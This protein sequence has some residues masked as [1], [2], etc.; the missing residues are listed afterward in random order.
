MGNNFFRSFW[1]DC[2]Y[3]KYNLEKYKDQCPP[4]GIVEMLALIEV[5]NNFNNLD[6]IEDV[7]LS[8]VAKEVL[9]RV[10]IVAK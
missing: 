5:G 9:Q 8:Q 6:K 3:Y 1:I 2:F 4:L 7:E 10:L